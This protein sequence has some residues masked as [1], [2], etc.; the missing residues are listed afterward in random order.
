MNERHRQMTI[1]AFGL[2]IAVG[3]LGAVIW[4]VLGISS[5]SPAVKMV[6]DEQQESAAPPV[7]YEA[8][9]S[10]PPTLVRSPLPIDTESHE[11]LVPI[12]VEVWAILDLIGP[13]ESS[14][15]SRTYRSTDWTRSAEGVVTVALGQ[16]SGSG[17]SGVISRTTLNRQS[18]SALVS[19]QDFTDAG[20]PFEFPWSNV[21]GHVRI[22]SWELTPD[23]R[24]EVELT[25]ELRGQKRS[26]HLCRPLDRERGLIR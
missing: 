15:S 25:G 14:D 10:H 26:L 21:Q 22:S 3:A 13:D 12:D 7:G 11:V 19:A 8:A 2:I 6:V 18:K 5:P 20:P 24:V 1:L 4:S 23:T 16:T 17:L 9:T